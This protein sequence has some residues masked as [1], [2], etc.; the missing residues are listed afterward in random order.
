MDDS[1]GHPP[2]VNPTINPQAN[3]Q[4]TLGNPSIGNQQ[5]AVGN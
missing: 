1:N 3:R 4:S 5:S 2:I